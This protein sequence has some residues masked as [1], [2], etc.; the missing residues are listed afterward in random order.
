[1]NDSVDRSGLNRGEL[2]RRGAAGAV[3]LGALGVLGC[4]GGSTSPGSTGAGDSRPPAKP[5]GSAKLGFGASG[6][7]YPIDPGGSQAVNVDFFRIYNCT[8]PLVDPSSP[9]VKYQMAT[10]IEPASKDGRVWD[11]TLRKALF[12][13]GRPVRAEDLIASVKIFGGPTSLQASKYALIKSAKKT[14]PRTVRFTM[15]VPTANF[16]T[17]YGWALFV[18]PE[19]FDL[20]K[21]IG[22]GPYVL[23]SWDP[24]RRTVLKPNPHYW[25]EGPY[26]ETI[27]MIE[28]ADD[29]ARVNALLARQ[30]DVIE[31]IPSGQIASLKGSAFNYVEAPSD[32]FLAIEMHTQKAPFNDVRVR[33]AFR[34]MIDRNAALSQVLDG[35]GTLGNDIFSKIDPN[36]PKDLP[37]REVDLEQAKS[38]LKAAGQADLTI[39]MPIAPVQGASDLAQVFSAQAQQAGVK[40]NIKQIDPT[41]YYTPQTGYLQ[42]P[43][44]AGGGA[45]PEYLAI[46]QLLLAPQAPFGETHWNDA[47]WTKLYNE[48]LATVDDAKR[49]ELVR[50]LMQ[51][52]YDRGGY[53]I[54]LYTPNTAAASKRIKG[55]K[56]QASSLAVNGARL[57][58]IWVE[59]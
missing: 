45:G 58:T 23:E 52:D 44:S 20:K 27:E 43:L 39:D 26:I 40:I 15:S 35:H 18:V 6:N 36:Y 3:G 54:P 25:G 10:S 53:V 28:F 55:L 24:K 2:L 49:S 50:G 1:M 21:P 56:P 12:S 33:Q 59:D 17:Q 22:T 16:V 19:D 4:G 32:V 30:V 42:H 41:T 29:T 14:G 34:L 47:A 7:K 38:L 8:E 13:D 51:I 37:Q 11:V 5:T 31:S 57:Q 46:S 48:A 9:T